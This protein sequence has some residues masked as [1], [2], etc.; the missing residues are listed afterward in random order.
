MATSFQSLVKRFA[1][2][3][4]GASFVEYSVLTALMITV[5]VGAIGLLSGQITV[6]FGNIVAALTGVAP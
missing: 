1:R 4:R 2:E 6:L 3:E 5:I